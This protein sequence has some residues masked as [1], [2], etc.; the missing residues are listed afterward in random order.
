MKYALQEM[1]KRAGYKSAKAFAAHIGMPTRT[2][3]NY[4][5]GVR[6]ITL[7]VAWNLADELGC[8]LDELAGRQWGETEM[9]SEAEVLLG[10]MTPKTREIMM[11]TL[12]SAAELDKKDT[13]F[14]RSETL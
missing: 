7:E 6:D 8:T 9:E 13:E 2:Y 3:T 4:E 10:S 12:R 5:Q 1:R 14:P 11:A